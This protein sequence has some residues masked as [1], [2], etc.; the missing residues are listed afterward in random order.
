MFRSSKS[1][2]GELANLAADMRDSPST[3]LISGTL[4]EARPFLLA[5][6]PHLVLRGV[7]ADYWRCFCGWRFLNFNR[8]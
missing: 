3:P 8:T 1:L 5:R 2:R 6:A 7:F 4:R